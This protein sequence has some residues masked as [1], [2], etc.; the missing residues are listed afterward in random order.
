MSEN[1]VTIGNIPIAKHVRKGTGE[2][3]QNLV[4]GWGNAP[5][6]ALVEPIAKFGTGPA[7]GSLEEE[8]AEVEEAYSRD[9]PSSFENGTWYRVIATFF[10]HVIARHEMFDPRPDSLT[11]FSIPYTGGPDAESIVFGTPEE[12][13]VEFVAKELAAQLAAPTAVA[14]PKEDMQG[15][16]I[17][18]EELEQAVYK[19]VLSSGRA[20]VGH[21]EEVHGVLIESFVVTDEKLT[22]MG[23]PEK[24]H[25][26][27]NKG[28]WLGF[29]V[30]DKTMDQV[31]SGELEMFSIGGGA[32]RDPD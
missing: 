5:F 18:M 15:D 4:F 7:A 24:V 22:A 30:D 19:F 17:P 31:E 26:Q 12:V 25:D 29:L 3:R 2:D 23:V 1:L 9:F 10:D 21:S 13:E 27:I 28:V 16:R 8:L 6:P 32:I 11:L 20:D 14:L